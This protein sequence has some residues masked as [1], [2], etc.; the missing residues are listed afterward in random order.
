M[1]EFYFSSFCFRLQLCLLFVCDSYSGNA[2]LNQVGEAIPL[3]DAS[4]D[5]V[6]G[7]LVLCSV[8]DVDNT[9]KGNLAYEG[10]NFLF[11]NL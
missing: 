7:T 8:K 6:V 10:Q 4:V 2:N 1:A 5:A 3:E 11:V 9:L